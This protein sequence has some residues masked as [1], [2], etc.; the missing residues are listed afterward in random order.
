MNGYKYRCIVTNIEK[1]VVSNSV[2]LNVV[3]NVTASNISVTDGSGAGGV[4]MIGDKITVT[5]NNSATGDNNTE[6]KEVKV[7]FSDYGGP[8]NESASKTSDIWKAEYTLTD[9]SKASEKNQITITVTDNNNQTTS[10]VILAKSFAPVTF[11]DIWIG[12]TRVSSGNAGDV[13]GNGTV[14]YDEVSNIL[15]FENASITSDEYGYDCDTNYYRRMVCIKQELILNL[16]GENKIEAINDGTTCFRW[17]GLYYDIDSDKPLTITGAGTLEIETGDVE[18]GGM[19]LGI[20]VSG[21]IIIDG[22]IVTAYSTSEAGKFVAGIYN[23]DNYT[24]TLKNNA[25]LHIYAPD[26]KGYMN[27]S[28]E[29]RYI[30]IIDETSTFIAQ[31][32]NGAGVDYLNF[33]FTAKP[34]QIVM[35]SEEY[36]GTGAKRIGVDSTNYKYIRI[37]NL[38]TPKAEDFSFTPPIPNTYDGTVKSANIISYKEGMGSITVK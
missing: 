25:K 18:T 16:I 37:V 35:G 21:P 28:G 27:N 11:Y 20:S 2:S 19:S 9:S 5:W 17:Y 15:T 36:D 14:R 29:N 22:C 31:G 7:D 4:Y 10:V 13:L 30:F 12:S 3:P 6:I 1:T 38:D 8:T 32:G 26:G 33:N 24:I 34:N 23:W